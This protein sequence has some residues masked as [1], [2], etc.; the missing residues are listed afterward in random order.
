MRV[1]FVAWFI[2][3]A[4]FAD[5]D[6]KAG[7]TIIRNG[8]RIS[9]EIGGGGAN[10]PIIKSGRYTCGDGSIALNVLVAGNEVRVTE[11]FNS[12][13]RVYHCSSLQCTGIDAPTRSL[14]L[15][16]E[17]RFVLNPANWSC[18]MW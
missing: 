9:C 8:E 5:V 16:S 3:T 18:G 2:S 1:F 7:D 6:L 12:W 17:T 14:S 15:L 13:T 4:A 10:L 11:Q